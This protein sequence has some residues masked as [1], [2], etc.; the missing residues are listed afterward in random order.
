MGCQCLHSNFQLRN[1]E[2]KGLLH[3]KIFANLKRRSAA[4]IALY[5]SKSSF[6]LSFFLSGTFKLKVFFS[7]FCFWISCINFAVGLPGL[8]IS[9]ILGKVK[10]I[11]EKLFFVVSSEIDIFSPIQV[12][13]LGDELFLS[14][15]VKNA[16]IR[17]NHAFVDCNAH[18]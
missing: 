2:G 15:F 6:L 10:L 7:Q 11:K 5:T 12:T 4:C 16:K 13:N 9:K 1:G 18:L 3:I 14:F 8:G 17:Q